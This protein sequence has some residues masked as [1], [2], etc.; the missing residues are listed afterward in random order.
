MLW[1]VDDWLGVLM[2]DI[3]FNSFAQFRVIPPLAADSG[4]RGIIH[5]N[6][7]FEGEFTNYIQYGVF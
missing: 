3:S 2:Q 7:H 1:F 6:C 5:G 4:K